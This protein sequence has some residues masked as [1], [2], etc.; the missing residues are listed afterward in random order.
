MAQTKFDKQLEENADSLVR[1][2]AR[3]LAGRDLD[4]VKRT[5]A[6]FWRAGTRVLPKVEG[7]VRRRSYKPGWRRL[8]FRI[9]LGAGVGEIGYLAT[10]DLDATVQNTQELGDHREPGDVGERRHRR[11]LRADRGHRGVHG[12]DPR[13]PE[14]GWTCH[15]PREPDTRGPARACGTARTHHCQWSLGG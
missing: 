12:A 3:V 14:A 5:D 11:G 2:I 1:G 7:K 13:A 15:G 10:Q 8:S 9:A 4:G 6:T